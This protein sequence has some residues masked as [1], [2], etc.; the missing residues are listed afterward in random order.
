MSKV[1][2]A[3]EAKQKS[4]LGKIGELAG[5][6]TKEKISYFFGKMDLHG[7]EEK[8]VLLDDLVKAGTALSKK[9]ATKEELGE[10]LFKAAYLCYAMDAQGFLYAPCHEP[11]RYAR[12]IAEKAGPAEFNHAMDIAYET[13]VKSANEFGQAVDLRHF[14]KAP[15]NL[16]GR[17]PEKE[18]N[19]LMDMMKI[20]VLAFTKE[21]L[22]TGEVL[23]ALG[24]ASKSRSFDEIG[25][26]LGRLSKIPAKF[27]P[28]RYTTEELYD[29]KFN[30]DPKV[31]KAILF[32]NDIGKV[33]LRR[34]EMRGDPVQA[35]D[36]IL[37]KLDEGKAREFDA[38]FRRQ[39]G[40]PQN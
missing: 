9:G 34:M 11:S 3:E 25:Q 1:I 6:D 2:T 22:S 16:A 4:L 20:A 17:F 18:F 8:V 27:V 5:Y 38:W 29:S 21:K 30:W 19:H 39:S 23:D 37:A 36:D 12:A 33:L 7:P 15:E 24:E 32:A 40:R 10:G 31:N 26:I 13:V 35:L 14:M 28:L